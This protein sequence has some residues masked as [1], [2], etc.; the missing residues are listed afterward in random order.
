MEK[1]FEHNILG[2]VC[3]S[4]AMILNKVPFCV[5]VPIKIRSNGYVWGN[6]GILQHPPAF[7]SEKQET[8]PGSPN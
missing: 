2:L 8:L 5:S 3:V 1:G 7:Y 4:D 6:W